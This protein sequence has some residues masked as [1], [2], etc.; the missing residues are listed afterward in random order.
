EALASAIAARER[1]EK[2]AEKLLAAAAKAKVAK[3]L[4]GRLRAAMERSARQTKALRAV[5]TGEAALKLA[6]AKLDEFLAA[7]RYGLYRGEA[8]IAFA[9]FWLERKLD[10]EKGGQWLQAAQKWLS[11]VGEAEVAL[12]KFAVPAA[13]QGVAAP[14][15]STFGTDNFGNIC[16]TAPGPG[17]VANRRTAAW[18]LDDLQSRAC[19]WQGFLAFV[20]GRMNKAKDLFAQYGRLSRYVQHCEKRDLPNP[21]YRL[22]VR[23]EQGTFRRAR[24]EEL[25]GFQ[26]RQR[27]FVVFMAD[28]LAECERPERAVR[29]YRRLLSGEFGKLSAPEEAYAR[30]GAAWGLW[31][32]GTENTRPEAQ[33]EAK[34]VLLAFR[35]RKELQRT[36]I[37]SRALV[38]LGNIIGYL[39]KKSPERNREMV[40]VYWLAANGQPP[41]SYVEDALYYIGDM[42]I[43]FPECRK[44]GIKALRR[45]KKDFGNGSYSNLMDGAL[46]EIMAKE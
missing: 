20:D 37:A 44:D 25:Q 21:L 7:N 26:S 6:G 16:F 45:L 39:A 32:Y 3:P 8:L 22:E 14:P 41:S 43:D 13:A 5:P 29:L 42:G 12:E 4:Q 11:E 35:D 23:C 31:Y 10:P 38:T 15:P 33:A 24:K 34:K 40:D 28:F 18:Y 9:D 17:Q 1:A 46:K 19:A 2:R 27:R 30:F 36:P